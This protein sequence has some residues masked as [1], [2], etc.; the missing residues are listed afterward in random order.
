MERSRPKGVKVQITLPE[1][2][3]KMVMEDIEANFMTKSSWFLKAVNNQ[4]E[5]GRINRPKKLI[6]LDN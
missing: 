1:D 2:I 3:Y 5:L 4:L 6:D